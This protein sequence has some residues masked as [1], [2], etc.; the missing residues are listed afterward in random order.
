[1]RANNDPGAY[2]RYVGVVD[3]KMKFQCYNNNNE[4]NGKAIVNKTINLT[5]FKRIRMTCH[6]PGNTSIQ[7]NFMFTIGRY[8][9]SATL[10]ITDEADHTL[11]MDVSDINEHMGLTITAS[12]NSANYFDVYVKKIEFLT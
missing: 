6:S 7:R 8:F 9:R 5:P 1:M 12:V 4:I 3:G 11:E 2:S 10:H